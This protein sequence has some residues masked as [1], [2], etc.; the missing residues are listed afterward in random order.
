MTLHTPNYAFPYGELSDPPDG[1]TQMENL[2]VAVDTQV[3]SNADAAAAALSAATTLAALK[4]ALYGSAQTVYY[5]PTITVA[6]ITPANTNFAGFRDTG[7]NLLGVAFVAPPSGRVSIKFGAALASSSASSE[8]QLTL[9]MNEGA[10]IG[11]GASVIAAATGNAVVTKSTTETMPE[12]SLVQ[13]GLTPGDT[14]NVS[15][16]W[17]VTLAGSTASAALPWIEITPLVV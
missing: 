16:T 4:A 12:R 1:A 13:F 17:K 14:L 7:A 5:A 10:V 11:A 15:F 6:S 3:K 2:A 9:N 8:V